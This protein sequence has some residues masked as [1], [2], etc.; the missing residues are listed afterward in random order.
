[1][2]LIANRG[3]STATSSQPF[4][5]SDPAPQIS[6]PDSASWLN[7]SSAVESA[8]RYKL[9]TRPANTTTIGV[10]LV[11]AKEGANWRLYARQAYRL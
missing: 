3:Q 1:M 11:W 9:T 7:S 4:C 5:A 10:L 6:S 2:Q 8:P